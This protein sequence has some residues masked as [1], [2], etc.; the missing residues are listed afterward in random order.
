MSRGKYRVNLMRRYRGK[1]KEE[2][3]Q[4]GQKMTKIIFKIGIKIQEE[5]KLIQFFFF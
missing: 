3:Q 2:G 1:V 4:T 5:S